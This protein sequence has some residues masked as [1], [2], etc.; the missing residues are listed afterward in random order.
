V[1]SIAPNDRGAV[2]SIFNVLALRDPAR[3]DAHIRAAAIDRLAAATDPKAIDEIG[4]G[5]NAK[6]PLV[7]EGAALA[8]GRLRSKKHLGALNK[9]AD[10]PD[11][12]VRRAALRAL[13][14]VGDLA[15][16]DML[17]KR[18]ER[19]ERSKSPEFREVL[20]IVDGLEKLTERQLGRHLDRWQEFWDKNGQGYKRPSEMTE[21]EKK[22]AEEK[23]KYKQEE[24]AKK[25][26]VTTTVRNIPIK[27]TKEGKGP[28][29]LLVIP[30]DSWRPNYLSPYLSSLDD[31]CEIYTV[32]LPSI[33]QLEI[34][35]RNIGG[36]PYW[37]YD[38]LC[39]AFD[40]IRKQYKHEKF[41]VLAH[42]FST[43]IGMHYLTKHPENVSHMILV[44]SFPG[45]DN[46]GTLL[47]KLQARA[48]TQLHDKELNHAVMFHWITDEKTFTYFYM[49]KS[50]QE[51]EALD[52]RFFSLMF[53]DPQDPE[54]AEIWDRCKKPASTDIAVM[55][56]EQCES[57][58]FDIMRE[59][60]PDTPVLVISGAKSL[61]FGEADGVRVAKN[62]P[63][64]EH[65]VLKN[66][67]M[68]P[69]F[70]ENGAFTQAV[71]DFFKK[72]PPGGGAGPAK[73]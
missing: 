73:R 39:D 13:R 40:E 6:D 46:Y 15:A 28:I 45:D 22:A 30:D 5:L 7:R 49:P 47:D 36:F 8:L 9:L 72:H 54:I 69:W 68:M 67:S 11:A 31:V 21:A 17:L 32:Q 33:T 70:E 60:H 59:K 66:S 42:G 63:V 16:V 51:L 57:P 56:K 37:P 64:S 24:D 52:R 38:E 3:M 14:D 35:K 50:N 34:K 26:E 44:G 55:K 27:L 4:K 43:M 19:M 10:D 12:G 20:A 25:E 71:K 58:P 62:Y 1:R 65:V 53:A 2:G 23:E 61:W 29:P 18:W 48:T 41:A